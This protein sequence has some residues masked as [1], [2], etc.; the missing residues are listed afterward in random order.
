M[1][2]CNPL[3]AVM[4]LQRIASSAHFRSDSGL[5]SRSADLAH[6]FLAP[7]QRASKTGRAQAAVPVRT[8]G[9]RRVVGCEEP[10]GRRS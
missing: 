4:A 10:S 7:L 8:V 2:D 3:L 9:T 1:T 6:Q 5:A